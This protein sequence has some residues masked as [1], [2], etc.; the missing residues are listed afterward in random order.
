M[1]TNFS[2]GKKE[3]SLG[4]EEQDRKW[5]SICARERKYYGKG[6][7]KQ[8]KLYCICVLPAVSY[9]A[10]FNIWCYD[11]FIFNLA[12]FLLTGDTRNK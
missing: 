1:N 4:W 2:M 9:H 11:L 6:F 3:P 5:G 12:H 7:W 8:S 10:W